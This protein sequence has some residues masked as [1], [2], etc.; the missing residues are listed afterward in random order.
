MRR[1]AFF[2]PLALTVSLAAAAQAQAPRV[3][4]A[5]GPTLQRDR[6]NLGQRDITEQA[7]RLGEAVRRALANS[8]YLDGAQVNLVLTDLKPNRPTIEQAN[9][10][11]GLSIIDSF[12]IGGAAIEG[13]VI[14]AD[15]RREPV[16]Y[17]RYSNDISWSRGMGTWWD[18]DRAFDRFAVNVAE[19]RL[20]S[21]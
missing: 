16:R 9:Q 7:D 12:S 6:D 2:A 5:L 8:D 10:R 20:V 14:L 3:T 19:G 13:E 1:L 11:P 17:S 4:V 21:R 15:G 18:A